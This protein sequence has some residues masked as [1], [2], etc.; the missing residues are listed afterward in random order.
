MPELY[1]FI[2]RELDA[3]ILQIELM[4]KNISNK[5]IQCTYGFDN[6]FNIYNC[7]GNNILNSNDDEYNNLTLIQSFQK[8][9]ERIDYVCTI[10]ND[11]NNNILY[12][13]NDIKFKNI[14]L[15]AYNNE[16]QN[17]TLIINELQLKL[18]DIQYKPFISIGSVSIT[19]TCILFAMTLYFFR[20]AIKK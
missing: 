2:Y 10:M 18:K 13:I 20:K 12:R 17:K 3:K 1:E 8:I 9:P 6:D 14:K 16:L 5:L 19:C 4:L 7:N 11:I 15:Q